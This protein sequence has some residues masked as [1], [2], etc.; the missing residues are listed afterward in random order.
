MTKQVNTI[1]SYRGYTY[2]DSLVLGANM[3][4][5]NWN[6]ENVIL[7][8]DF[9]FD[10]LLQEAQ[11]Q[12]GTSTRDTIKLIHLDV[13]RH[14]CYQADLISGLPT[15][16]YEQSCE[17]QERCEEAIDAFLNAEEAA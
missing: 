3:F 11:C 9:L 5:S 6:T 2:E 1:A 14:F 13:L 7:E 15:Y 17:Q 10:Q 8:I 4:G 12:Q 16:W